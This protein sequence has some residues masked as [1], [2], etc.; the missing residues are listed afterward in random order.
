MEHLIQEGIFHRDLAARNVL[1]FSFD[2]NNHLSTSVKVADFGL[3]VGAY[4]QTHVYTGQEECRPLRYMPPETLRKGRCI[5][6]VM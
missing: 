4:D 2:Q 5:H 1:L 6:V 3:S